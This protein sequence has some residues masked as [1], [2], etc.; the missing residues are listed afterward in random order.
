MS[1]SVN[2]VII[3]GAL[4]ADPEVKRTQSGNVFVNMRVATSESWKDKNTGEKTERVEWHRI[5]IWNEPLAKV[6]EQYLKKGS[7]VYL[8]GQLE[9]R[10]WQ[11]QSGNDRYSTEVVLRPYTSTLKLMG[12]PAG[13]RRQE[14]EEPEERSQGSYGDKG[15]DFG[16][17]AGAQRSGGG[18]A[19][20][21]AQSKRDE[22]DDDIPF[23][24]PIDIREKNLF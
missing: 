20:Q 1:S 19:R 17:N 18:G 24:H 9:T 3:F 11:D 13:S 12:D 7:K 23:V 2:K 6:A 16:N 5:T 14:G 22:M 4:G 15:S 8:E 21:P 10:K